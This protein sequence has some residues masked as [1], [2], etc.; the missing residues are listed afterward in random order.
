MNSPHIQCSLTPGTSKRDCPPLLPALAVLP[1]RLVCGPRCR[2]GSGSH[3]S[4]AGSSKNGLPHEGGS[5]EAKG[6]HGTGGVLTNQGTVLLHL[7]SSP[8]R[9]MVHPDSPVRSSRDSTRVEARFRSPSR[10][11]HWR[12]STSN[13]SLNPPRRQGHYLQHNSEKNWLPRHKLKISS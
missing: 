13:I 11:Q 12:Q 2:R 5:A 7:P 1:S 4:L 10:R 9:R 3:P 8:T 6:D